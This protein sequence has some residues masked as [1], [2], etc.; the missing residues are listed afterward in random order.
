MQQINFW[1]SDS[2][3]DN[4]IVLDNL[5]VDEERRLKY[6]ARIVFGVDGDFENAFKSFGKDIG[7]E[8][9]SVRGIAHNVL[10][11]TTNIIMLGSIALSKCA[12]PS[13]AVLGY[14]LFPL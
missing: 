11:V 8:F 13:H 9:L 12:S 6:V 7:G 14:S 10:H 1:M 3:S 2:A 4:F 5:E